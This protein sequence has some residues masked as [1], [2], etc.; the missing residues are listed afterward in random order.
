M[1]QNIHGH[2]N[3]CLPAAIAV[4]GPLRGESSSGQS[5]V[6]TATT[7]IGSGNG[8]S[9]GSG[10]C[11]F[12]NG[13]NDAPMVSQNAIAWRSSSDAEC[14]IYQPE[15]DTPSALYHELAVGDVSTGCPYSIAETGTPDTMGCAS[16]TS[17]GGYLSIPNSGKDIV[18]Q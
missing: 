6:N 18:C 2:F 8:G 16:V 12:F 5:P 17:I 4:N 11:G 9:S 13:R 1:P 14:A 3:D 10:S 15:S 7:V